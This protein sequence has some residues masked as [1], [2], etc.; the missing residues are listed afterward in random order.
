MEAARRHA[1]FCGKSV[2]GEI[3]ARQVRVGRKRPTPPRPLAASGLRYGWDRLPP[4]GTILGV[5]V[6]LP[7]RAA[8]IPDIGRRLWRCGRHHDRCGCDIGGH[9]WSVGDRRYH[10][11]RGG[12][13]TGRLARRGANH[14]S[15]QPQEQQRRHPTGVTVAVAIFPMGLPVVASW[16]IGQGIGTQCCDQHCHK[17]GPEEQFHDAAPFV[18]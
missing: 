8:E 15:G 7:H 17:E 18:A 16:S 3:I 10:I 6:V 12:W 13:R 9:R 4:F 1:A 14:R 11:H 2:A 5:G